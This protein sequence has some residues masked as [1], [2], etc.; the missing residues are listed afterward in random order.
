MGMKAKNVMT[1]QVV[2]AKPKASLDD[3]FALLLRHHVSG[4]PVVD[5]EG[6][7]LGVITEYDLLSLLCDTSFDSGIVSDFLTKDVVTVNENE[8]LSDIAELFMSHSIRRIPVLRDGKIVGI[9]SRRDLIRYI[10][11]VRIHVS[12]Q[13][14]KCARSNELTRTSAAG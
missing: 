12:R 13:L 4:L 1:T 7:L 11:E 14:E 5:D 9:I 3:V 8:A 2:S 10:R 6:F